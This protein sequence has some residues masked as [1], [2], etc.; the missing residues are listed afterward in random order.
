MGNGR[1]KTERLINEKP[2]KK[3]NQKMELDFLIQ[4]VCWGKAVRYDMEKI[5]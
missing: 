3:E 4:E 5:S 2:Y 1:R